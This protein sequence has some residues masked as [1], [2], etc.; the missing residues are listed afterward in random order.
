MF[1]LS[2]SAIAKARVP[3][4]TRTIHNTSMD[5]VKLAEVRDAV[6][7]EPKKSEPTLAASSLPLSKICK[8]VK[9]VNDREAA[10]ARAIDNDME[11]RRVHS[12]VRDTSSTQA[13]RST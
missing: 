5:A 2:I 9:A 4:A 10:H 3:A 11:F 8:E 12:R 7:A 1:R 13:L 6:H